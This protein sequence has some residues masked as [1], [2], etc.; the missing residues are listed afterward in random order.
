ML[1]DPKIDQCG[2][3]KQFFFSEK[4]AEELTHFRG[5]QS[6]GSS[7]CLKS[8]RLP[9]FGQFFVERLKIVKNSCKRVVISSF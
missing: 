2:Q 5:F 3:E 1:I 8:K 9:N 6:A 4:N 7:V